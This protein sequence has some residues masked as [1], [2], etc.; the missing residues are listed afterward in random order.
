MFVLQPPVSPVSDEKTI[1]ARANETTGD[2]EEGTKKFYS[3]T[4]VLVEPRK[5]F[6][7]GD[8]DKFTI[9]VYLE[10]DDPDCIDALIGGEIKMHMDIV[11]EHIKQDGTVE[12]VNDENNNEENSNQETNINEQQEEVKEEN[13]QQEQI[14]EEE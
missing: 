14:N 3:A 7:P 6:K 11:E 5:R 2:P 12:E 10:G 13:E 4:E 8:V 9:V 1:Y